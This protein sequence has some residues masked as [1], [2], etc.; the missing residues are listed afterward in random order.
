MKFVENL[1]WNIVCTLSLFTIFI[2]FNFQQQ[3]Q[4]QQQQS[5]QTST[6]SQPVN[7]YQCNTL[8]TLLFV[9]IVVRELACTYAC[10]Q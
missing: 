9:I 2:I 3:Q 8:K 1:A 7:Q 4:K 5:Q 10:V 6:A